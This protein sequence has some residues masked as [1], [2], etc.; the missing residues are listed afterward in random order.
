MLKDLQLKLEEAEA[1]RK[2]DAEEAQAQRKADQADAKGQ[3]R[4]LEMG[5]KELEYDIKRLE[6]N[7]S[8]REL[9]RKQKDGDMQRYIASGKTGIGNCK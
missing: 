6:Q 4:K 8:E 1:Q 3:I 5:I 7:A 9:E 2:R